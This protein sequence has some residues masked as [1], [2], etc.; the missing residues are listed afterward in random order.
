MILLFYSKKSESGEQ[1]RKIVGDLMPVNKRLETCHCIDD[2]SERMRH[3]MGGLSMIILLADT[4]DDLDNLLTLS[5]IFENFDIIL[6][7]PD[8][9]PGTIFKGYKF[10]PRYAGFKNDDFSELVLILARMIKKNQNHK[11]S[12]VCHETEYSGD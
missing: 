8:K 9:T 10:F 12:E 11:S 7:L 5:A 6:I 1:I 2:L 3:P 4:Q